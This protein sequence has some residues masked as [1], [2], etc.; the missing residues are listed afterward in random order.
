MNLSWKKQKS[1]K[2]YFKVKDKAKAFHHILTEKKGEG[3]QYAYL[4]EMKSYTLQTT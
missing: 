1:K 4:K 2:S 3:D